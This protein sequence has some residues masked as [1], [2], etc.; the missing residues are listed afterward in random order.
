MANGPRLR[1]FLT[2]GL[3]SWRIALMVTGLVIS[4]GGV[5]IFGWLWG[6]A[7]WSTGREIAMVGA[8]VV[9]LLIVLASFIGSQ[10]SPSAG[11]AD[12]SG[13]SGLGLLALLPIVALPMLFYLTRL[14][15][16]WRVILA[17]GCVGS[18][19]AIALFARRRA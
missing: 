7:V 16:E 14:S 6:A 2:G 1:S 13:G 15:P 19:A 17:V 18:L 10:T 3:E 5:F 12:A 8:V 11:D 9:G 4:F